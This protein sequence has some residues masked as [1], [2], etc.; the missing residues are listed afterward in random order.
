MTR[1]LT[2]H[3]IQTQ[4]FFVRAIREAAAGVAPAASYALD[5]NMQTSIFGL[6]TNA[7]DRL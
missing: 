1:M 2:F 3:Q 4:R 6:D 7:N 5:V